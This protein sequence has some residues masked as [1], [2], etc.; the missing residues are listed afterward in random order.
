MLR[1][2]AI[3]IV[4]ILALA[5]NVASA[6]HPFS[7]NYDALKAGMLS[8]KIAAVQ[9]TN[10]HVVF[11]LDVESDGNTERWMVEGYP[12]NTLLRK[13]WAKDSLRE[14]SQITV[15]GWHARDTT[16]KIFSGHEVT[17]TDGTTRVFGRAPSSDGSSAEHWKCGRSDC[18]NWIPSIAN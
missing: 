1:W 15:S 16:L 7:V 12:P 8:G 11:A 17:F 6:H 5:V 3:G 2:T 4:P 18:P 13:G 10:P 14:G 9:W